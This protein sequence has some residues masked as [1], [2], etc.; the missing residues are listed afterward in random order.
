MNFL[1][2]FY[3][4]HSKKGKTKFILTQI[5]KIE[6]IN[7]TPNTLPD[8]VHFKHSGLIGDLIYSIPAMIA[9]AKGKKIHLHL[10]INQKAI[11]KK[12][13]RHHNNNK[14]LN[15]GSVFFLSPLFLK[16]PNFVVCDILENQRVDYDLDILRK[17]PFI[18]NTHNITRLN[19][20][21]FG[22]SSDLSKPW[23]FV[24]PDLS[25]ENEIIIARSFRYRTPGID[26]SFL[27]AY[28]NLTFVGLEDEFED[29]K[30]VIP[31]LKYKLTKNAY[32]L[33]SVI[34]GSK[35]FIGNQ[36]FPFAIAEALKVSRVLEIYYDRPDVIVIGENAY[37]FYL[38]KQ[39]EKIINTILNTEN[40]KNN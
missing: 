2:R 5:S 40:E 38:Q 22:V 31:S 20:L 34:N 28:N 13:M 30:K 11:Y 15:E 14:M 19:L 29:M 27:E 32:E 33:A 35:L 17:L 21:T 12:N 8:E 10:N 24:K 1:K 18:L 36:S 3:L 23:L 6:S 9:L 4:K 25:F 39:F 16:Q 37:D 26:Y 7:L